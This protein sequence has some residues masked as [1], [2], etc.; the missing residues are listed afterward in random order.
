[1][2]LEV[3][4]EMIGGIV[5]VYDVHG[6]MVKEWRVASDKWQVNVSDLSKGLYIVIAE[7]EGKFARAKLVVE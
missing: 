3:S 1:M 2:Q 4:S 6:R 7:Q 5:K